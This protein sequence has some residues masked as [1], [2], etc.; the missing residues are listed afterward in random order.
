MPMSFASLCAALTVPCLMVTYYI[1]RPWRWFS[2]HP[3]L[4]TLAFVAAAGSGILVKRRGGR[5]NT[6]AHGYAMVTAFAMALGGWYVI[7]QQKIMLGKPH[8]TSW[9]SWQGV[10]ACIG[11]GVGAAVGL[12]ALHPDHGLWRTSQRI[13]LA[14]KM[15]SRVATAAALLAMGSGYAKLADGYSPAVVAP[16][17]VALAV[18]LSLFEHPFKAVGHLPV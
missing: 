15:T 4:M 1:G 8:N 18:G 12:S 2:L 14:H 7:Y 5:A 3:L 9:H 17:L 6:L 11:Y 10:S 13:R 16:S